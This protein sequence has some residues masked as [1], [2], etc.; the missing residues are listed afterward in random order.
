MVATWATFAPCF[1]WIFLGRPTSSGFAGTSGWGLRCRRITAAVVGVIANLARD[2][3]ASRRC[4]NGSVTS[5]WWAAPSRCAIWSSVDVFAV[6]V[7]VVSFVGLW[8]L[9]WKVIPVVAASAFAGLV[10]NGL[11]K[12]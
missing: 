10:V 5:A 8:R 2:V 6:L 3:R 9:K 4:S 12:G 11:F 7:A 1:L